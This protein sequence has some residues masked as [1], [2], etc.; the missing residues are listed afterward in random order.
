MKMDI[1]ILGIDVSKAT[2]NVALLETD[3]KFKNRKF[4]NNPKGF[5]ELQ[6]WLLS[7]KLTDLHAC[8]EST[9]RY[10]NQ[11]AMYLHKLGFKVS[12]VNPARIK[13]FGISKLTRVKTDKADGK[14][15]AIFCQVMRPRLWQ[16][17]PEEIMLVK[18]W[19]DRLDNLIAFK[20]QESNRLECIECLDAS[21]SGHIKTSIVS[22]DQQIQNAE[23]N[24]KQLIQSHPDLANK[25]KLL[26]SIPGIGVKTTAYILAL[27]PIEKF[28]SAKK[29]IAFTGLNPKI[30]QSGTSLNKHKSISKMGNARLRKAF[31]MSALVAIRYNP[32]VKDFAE[33]LIEAG[34]TKM[35]TVIAA[36]RKLIHIVYGVLKNGTPFTVN[37]GKNEKI[38]MG[39]LNSLT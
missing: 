20:I 19:V 30:N 34:K 14:L 6:A 11:L 1:P 12:V 27:L 37:A 39:N 33:R 15:I 28:A 10:G 18:Q 38:V 25:A 4:A 35:T 2:F 3:N 16:P 17:T 23:E 24:I 36:M 9:G 7:N 32:M 8:M 13:A 29:L 5:E 31:Y 26:A 22:L 21:I